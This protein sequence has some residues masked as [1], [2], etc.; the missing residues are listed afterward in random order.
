MAISD[1]RYFVILPPKFEIY[2]FIFEWIKVTIKS[3]NFEH[4]KAYLY[5]KQLANAHHSTKFQIDTS[6]FDHQK[7]NIFLQHDA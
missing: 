1:F 7:L 3:K 6:I 4:E 2:F 5:V